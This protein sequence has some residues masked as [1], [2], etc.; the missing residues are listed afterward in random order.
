MELMGT[1]EGDTVIRSISAICLPVRCCASVTGG[2]WLPFQPRMGENRGWVIGE[3][4]DLNQAP[5]I[6]AR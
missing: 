1:D 5:G 2:Q 6:W 4:R 3:R